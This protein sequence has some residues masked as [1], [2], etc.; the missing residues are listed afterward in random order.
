MRVFGSEE[1]SW[2]SMRWIT[3]GQHPDKQ[4]VDGASIGPFAPASVEI[5]TN[6]VKPA[7]RGEAPARTDVP[8]PPVS[9]SPPQQRGDQRYGHPLP[10]SH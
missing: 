6:P 9:H 3:D 2:Q 8:L 10:S 5:G 7:N 1:N 4:S